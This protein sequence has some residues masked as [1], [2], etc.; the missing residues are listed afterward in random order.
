MNLKFNKLLVTIDK[1]IKKKIIIVLN[2]KFSFL[3]SIFIL[4][5]S[6][7]KKFEIF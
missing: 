4:I 5:N 6:I 1:K 2:S 3:N 7:E